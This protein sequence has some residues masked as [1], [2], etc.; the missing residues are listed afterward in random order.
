MSPPYHCSLMGGTIG[1]S[2]LLSHHSISQMLTWRHGG[3]ESK[4]KMPEAVSSM[5][6]SMMRD[7]RTEN[8][9]FFVTLCFV[10]LNV[11]VSRLREKIG[12]E[13]QERR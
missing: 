7:E 8:S 4:M 2:V 10:S 1:I 5:S 12:L 3:C 11:S 9:Q 6:M 13:I